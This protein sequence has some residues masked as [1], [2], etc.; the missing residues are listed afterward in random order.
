MPRPLRVPNDEERSALDI[1]RDINETIQKN[2]ERNKNLA[3]DRRARVQR[4][5]D[6][7]WSMYGIGKETGITPN[8]VKRILESRREG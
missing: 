6:D 4:L 3:A 8:T 5:I 2:I 7:G 1:V